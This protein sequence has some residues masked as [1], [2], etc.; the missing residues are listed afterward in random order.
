MS[1]PRLLQIATLL[2]AA[3]L[4]AGCDSPEF[5]VGPVRS[6]TRPAGSFDSIDLDGSARL[7][8]TIGAAESLS[9]E[10]PGRILDQVTTEVRRHTLRIR[11]RSKGWIWVHGQPR[12]V[13]N[14]TVPQLKSLEVKG[15]NDVRLTGFAG[16]K[17]NI[18][19]QGAAHVQ[20][21]GSLDE[22]TVDMNGAGVA[23]LDELVTKQVKVKVD[24]IGR[25]VVHPKDE[26]NAT[27]NGIGA[28]LYVGQP[29]EVRTHMNGLGS[30]AQQDPEETD[31]NQRKKDR[32]WN[33]HRRE[34]APDPQLDPPPQPNPDELQPEYDN[35][36]K[37]I[38]MTKVI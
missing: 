15:G 10:G 38:D 35:R 12:V 2:L 4:V 11:T 18:S 30:I 20:A 24:G 29:R 19:I 3:L 8:I 17:S 33:Q 6:E 37:K 22:L 32:E 21:S 31:R 7:N 1:T 5:D 26:L 34:Q 16:G 36:P 23:D 9:L 28:I 13:V 25:V 27:M 14:I